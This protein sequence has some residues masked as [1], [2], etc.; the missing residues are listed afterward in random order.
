MEMCTGFT[1]V[2]NT[3]MYSV[4]SEPAQSSMQADSS[5]KDSSELL[6]LHV[7]LT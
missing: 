3:K 4:T 5:F 2:G 1:T 7:E 6:N